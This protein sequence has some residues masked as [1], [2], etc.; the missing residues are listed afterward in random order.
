MK[1]TGYAVAGL[2]VGWVARLV[3]DEVSPPYEVSRSDEVSRQFNQ[4]WNQQSET[5]FHFPEVTPVNSQLWQDA[6][7]ILE[8]GT[9]TFNWQWPY[10][11]VWYSTSST[12]NVVYSSTVVYCYNGSGDISCSI[13]PPS[14][15][16][17]T[18]IENAGCTFMAVEPRR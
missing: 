9:L 13:K 15:K 4:W 8:G 1:L 14:E 11:M 3:H 6:E 5:P 12:S 17:E 18:D 7:N 10:K 2:V 16:C